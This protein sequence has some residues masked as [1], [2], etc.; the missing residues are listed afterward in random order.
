MNDYAR[1]T[2]SGYDTPK[3]SN[4]RSGQG[5]EWPSTSAEHARDRLTAQEVR[6][7]PQ[8]RQTW[9]RLTPWDFFFFFFF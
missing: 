1:E 7:P 6:R 8:E 3:V 5:S 4:T 2:R 9:V